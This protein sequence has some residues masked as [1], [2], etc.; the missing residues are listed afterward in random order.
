MNVNSVYIFPLDSFLRWE[1]IFE[2][3]V[4]DQGEMGVQVAGGRVGVAVN[5]ALGASLGPLS[6][7][8]TGKQGSSRD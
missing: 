2:G 5:I 7:D 6:C 8:L 3:T 4:V 1:S